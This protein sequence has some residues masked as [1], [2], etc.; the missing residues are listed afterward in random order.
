M[1]GTPSSGDLHTLAFVMPY[2]GTVLVLN[3][4][5]IK[6]RFLF[7]C[8]FM[9]LKFIR[10]LSQSFFAK[11]NQNDDN[12]HNLLIN[13]NHPKFRFG[14]V[15]LIC[16]SKENYYYTYMFII[17]YVK[18]LPTSYFS[19]SVFRLYITY[20]EDKIFSIFIYQ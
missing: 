20:V 14:C 4:F 5:R 12:Y 11:Q 1:I 18:L 16:V 15:T 6:R 13:L 17:T 19:V 2:D 9:Q 3:N 7:L 8:V 10:F